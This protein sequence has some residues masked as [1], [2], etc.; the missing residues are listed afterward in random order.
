MDGPKHYITG[1]EGDCGP[2]FGKEREYYVYDILTELLSS[3]FLQGGFSFDHDNGFVIIFNRVGYYIYFDL[4]SNKIS[5]KSFTRSR[6][7]LIKY[8]HII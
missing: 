8:V 1:D 4:V 6:R 5:S 7:K 2:F 3:A